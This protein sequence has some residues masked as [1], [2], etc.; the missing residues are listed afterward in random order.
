M[1]LRSTRQ[2][3]HACIA[4][5]LEELSPAIAETQPEVLVHHYAKAALTAQAIQFWLKAGQ[6]AIRRS[7]AREASVHA[8]RGLALLQSLPEGR[9]RDQTELELQNILGAALL[10]SKG[11]AAPET[12]AAYE[13]A[14][15]LIRNGTNIS[16]AGPVLMGLNYAYTNMAAHEKAI[17][18]GKELLEAGV[19]ESDDASACVAH[20]MITVAHLMMGD[21]ALARDHAEH[22]WSAYDAGK[23]RRLAYRYAYEL[24]VGAMTNLAFAYWFLGHLEQSDQFS[25]RALAMADQSAHSNTLGYALCYAGA[26]PSFN[27]RNYPA[28]GRFARRLHNVAAEQNMPQWMAWAMCLE[29]PAL[30]RVGE[31]KMAIRQATAGLAARDRIGNVSMRPL[32]L[33]IIAEL[34]IGSR[35]SEQAI[36]TIKEARTTAERTRERYMDSE[37]WRLQ[38]DA[39][40]AAGEK[41]A[42]AE[43]EECYRRA[44]ATPTARIFHLRAATSLARLLSAADRR[45]E[46]LAMLAPSIPLSLRVLR[47]R[48]LPTRREDSN[49]IGIADQLP[50]DHVL[51]LVNHDVGM[52]AAHRP[53]PL[54]QRTVLRHQPGEVGNALGSLLE[55][56]LLQ[57]L[58]RPRGFRQNPR[59]NPHVGQG[60]VDLGPL[61]VRI[62]DECT[63]TAGNVPGEGEEH[64]AERQPHR[65][66]G[67]RLRD[68]QDVET[69]RD[70]D[71]LRDAVLLTGVELA[72]LHAPRHTC[73]VG[74]A[75]AGAG[76]QVGEGKRRAGVLDDRGRPARSLGNAL[77]HR[78]GE[79]VG[80]A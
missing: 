72:L 17:A 57:R 62:G 75:S 53:C 44:V 16:L 14:R 28:L 42:S 77:R 31:A 15:S 23:H 71:D 3:L 80:R 51:I 67:L 5:I 4:Q 41:A 20:Q 69:D 76:T 6:L 26:I 27:L 18:V 24:G 11:A 54:S 30:A 60:A 47:R 25:T 50:S 12:V 48:T 8:I 49:G 9:D 45:E 63:I 43:A 21:Y 34:H 35:R 22:A 65:W 56:E 10:A 70:L 59:V 38:G 74:M 13:R 58:A 36:Q 66:T 19:R 46:A 78:R 55:K 79:G 32:L 64:L 37:L 39:L 52:I 7:A 40:L 33:A 68:D 73:R 1:L 2:Q 29:A 61:A